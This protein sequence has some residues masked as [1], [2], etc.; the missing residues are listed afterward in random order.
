MSRGA[1]SPHRRRPDPPLWGAV[2]LPQRDGPP[3]P[4]LRRSR[5]DG[6]GRPEPIEWLPPPRF[7]DRALRAIGAPLAVGVI[8]F[9]AAVA[10]AVVLALA[11]SQASNPGASEPGLLPSA[12]GDGSVPAETAQ[13]ET[14]RGEAETP[15]LGGDDA[16]GSGS[17]GRVL[18]HVVGK[19]RSPGVV[20]LEPGSRVRDAIEQA[21][22]T[23]DPAALSGVNLARQVVDGEQIVV[24]RLRT[25]ATPGAGGDG[26][27]PG[28]GS[29]GRI[30]LNGA[31]ATELERLPGVGPALAARII[32]WRRAHGAFTK[33][34][35]LGEISGIGPKTLEGLREQV[36]L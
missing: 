22:G 35:Q 34:E 28:G 19:V 4:A 13:G 6:S 5:T 24:A 30:S 14:A 11:Q 10:T 1:A 36:T 31:D 20:E 33:V 9:T 7:R 25:G 17:N 23:T 15:G 21:G 26:A 2:P 12:R 18:V 16:S 8:V 32:E 29:A 3:A 27:V